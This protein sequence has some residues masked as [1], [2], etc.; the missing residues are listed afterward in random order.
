MPEEQLIVIGYGSLMSGF[1]LRRGSGIRLPTVG[2]IGLRNARRGFAKLSQHSDC[3]A[4]ALEPVESRQPI[5]GRITAPA[6]Y[7]H[8][9]SHES[10][11]TG[12]PEGVGFHVSFSA[13]QA[14]CEREGYDYTAMQTLGRQAAEQ[15]RST[16]EWL[17]SLACDARHDL[18]GYRR[19][20]FARTGYA[21]PHYVPHPVALDDGR[22]AITF[23]APGREGSGCDEVVPVRVETG[24]LELLD[25][26][27][28]W[29]LKG[30]EAQLSYFT[31]CLLAAVHRVAV[32]DLLPDPEDR[33]LR[34][35]LAARLHA[36]AADEPG[37]FCEATGLDP[38]AR[39]VIFAAPRDPI[40]ALAP[41]FGKPGES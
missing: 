32:D 37:W 9:V 18:A 31:T 41:F 10:D 24:H 13:L 12:I 29:R 14:V 15:G 5:R 34:A 38:Q 25:A 1:G 8:T 33:E 16:S 20:L 6:P 21:S 26:S 39:T 22:V 2:R 7:P 27:T 40:D 11:A 17:W 36:L 35:A 4:M 19:A 23:L 3:F 28:A 30:N